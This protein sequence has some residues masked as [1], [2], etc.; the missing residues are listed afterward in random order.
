VSL[1]PEFLHKKEPQ[2]LN[3]DL[4]NS[5]VRAVVTTAFAMKNYKRLK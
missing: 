1:S 5:I 3:G 4:L 2:K